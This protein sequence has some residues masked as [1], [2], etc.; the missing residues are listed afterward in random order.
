[1]F[2]GQSQQQALRT[3]KVKGY[4]SDVDLMKYYAFLKHLAKVAKQGSEYI[5]S[6][7]KTLLLPSQ[8]QGGENECAQG[9]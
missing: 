6:L 2:D 4:P 3:N 8:N 1:M 5:Q 9:S 7:I